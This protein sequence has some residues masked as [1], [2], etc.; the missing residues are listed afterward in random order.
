MELY[1]LIIILLYTIAIILAIWL[2]KKVG[3]VLLVL[4]LLTIVV[5]GVI[6]FLVYKDMVTIKAETKNGVMVVLADNANLLSGFEVRGENPKFFSKDQLSMLSAQYSEGNLKEM[7]GANFK[8]IVIKMGAIEEMDPFEIEMEGS[9]ITKDQALSLLRSDKPSVLMVGGVVAS[10]EPPS[11]ELKALILGD[12][13]TRRI[14]Q[15]P[16]FAIAQLKKDNLIIYPQTAIFR[17]VE[18]V[19]AGMIE[20]WAKKAAEKGKE[21]KEMVAGSLA[22]KNT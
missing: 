11:E 6:G 13:F 8:L 3:K 18:Y 5:F 2:L 22:G 7:K 19:P 9:A 21:G 15:D 10:Q 17:I 12:I 20:N 1:G 16:S 4:F 14:I